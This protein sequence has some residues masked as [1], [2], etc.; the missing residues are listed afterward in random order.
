MV[1][2]IFLRC[3][4]DRAKE[5]QVFVPPPKFDKP[6]Q[7]PKLSTPDYGFLRDYPKLPKWEYHPIAL[8]K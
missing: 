3:E 1:G 8:A 6:L 2:G 4:A 5:R 7:L